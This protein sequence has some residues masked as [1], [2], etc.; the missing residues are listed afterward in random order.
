MEMQSRNRIQISWYPQRDRIARLAGGAA[1]GAVLAVMNPA[2]AAVGRARAPA[3]A[4]AAAERLCPGVEVAGELSPGFSGM[5]KR[6]ICGDPDHSDPE[7][8]AWA[9]IPKNQAR[10]HLTTFLQ[11]RGRYRPSFSEAADGALRVDIGPPTYARSLTQTGAPPTLDLGR[12][13]EVVGELLTPQLLNSVETW[14]N[15]E[16]GTLGYPCPQVKSTADVVTGD[17]RVE[18]DPGPFQDLVS[19][20]EDP[21]EGLAPGMLRRYDAFRFGYPYDVDLLTVTASRVLSQGIVQSIYFKSACGKEG[22]VVSQGTVAGPPRILSFSIGANTQELLRLQASWKNARLGRAGSLVEVS[23]LASARRQRLLTSLTWYPFP[24]PSRRYFKPLL[25]VEHQNRPLLESL[26]ARTELTPATSWDNRTWGVGW[27]VGPAFEAIR[28]IRGSGQ[29]NSKFLSL[30]QEL[31]AMSHR[32]ELYQ[33]SPRAGA[34]FTFTSDLNSSALGSDTSAQRFRL[35]GHALWNLRDYD[36]PLLILGGRFGLSSTVAGDV[37]AVPALYR[38]ALGGSS[39]LRGFGLDELPE[40]H[41]GRLTEVF[42]GV[43]ARLVTVLPLNL[44]PLAFVDAGRLG[45]RPF[46]LDPAWYWSPGAG[47]RWESPIGA[48]RATVAHGYVTGDPGRASSHLQFFISL[49]EEF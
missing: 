12:K 29:G 22:A 7:G 3:D 18:I 5:E 45:A 15:H 14:V 20:S 17:I 44:Q 11:D 33:S 32:Y 16:L 10:F 40:D 48:V 2:V 27:R 8:R 19:I 38:Y 31:T 37:N 25:L 4:R 34:S 6:L 47:V 41:Q 9:E 46:S 21:I 26:S 36:P 24:E 30:T 39:D 1:I 23:A 13:R 42:A 28:T 35:A 43:E 49:G